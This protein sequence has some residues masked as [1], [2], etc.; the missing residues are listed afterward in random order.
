MKKVLI[1]GAQGFIGK[2]L[3]A[4]LC[5]RDDVQVITFDRDASEAMLKDALLQCDFIFHLAG[6]NRPKSEEEFELGNTNFTK[7]LCALIEAQ[8]KCVPILYTSSIQVEADNSYGKSKLAAE[9]ALNNYAIQC[10][11]D[12][13]NFRLPNVFGK[14]AKPNYNSA[15]ATFCYNTVHDL[16]IEIHNADAVI[17]L[18]YIDDV[19]AQ[20]IRVMDGESDSCVIDPEYHISVGSLAEKLQKFKQSRDNITT[21][22]VGT[23]LDRALHA[24]YLS[25]L[26]PK[27]F[28]YKL[29]KH[30]D[31]RGVFVEMLR[32]HDSGQFSYFTAH[33]GVTRGGHY[34]HSKTEKFLVVKGKARFKF[35]HIVTG[36]FYTLDTNDKVPQVVETVPG[37]THDITNVGNDEMIV[38]LW[39]N[40]RFNSEKPDTYA[41]PL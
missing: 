40:E 24:T 16:P 20:F 28:A 26:Q 6:I 32:T 1:T 13:H 17:R 30:E 15:V 34:H 10:D 23:G 18:V 31:P 3:Q 7:R 36:E 33:P 11:I 29:I 21:E 27:Q 39:A 25:Y 9:E 4:H 19:V 14:W 35:K 2:N 37:W 22:P 8:G 5:E 41:Q 38:L 12:V